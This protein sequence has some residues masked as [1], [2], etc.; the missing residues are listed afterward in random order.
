MCSMSCFN[1]E[2]DISYKDSTTGL[3]VKYYIFN[4]FKH[5]FDKWSNKQRLRG[6]KNKMG[7]RGEKQ[8]PL[9]TKGN[10]Y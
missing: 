3:S 4:F 5:S 1:N 8:K 6:V 10:M 7:Y 2:C 9:K